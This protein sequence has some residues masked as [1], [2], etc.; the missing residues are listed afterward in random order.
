MLTCY[1]AADVGQ[2]LLLPEEGSA[3]CSFYKPTA[4]GAVTLQARARPVTQG[5][6]KFNLSKLKE[7]FQ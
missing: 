1:L 6:K 2:K 4:D 7:I 5:W 3:H